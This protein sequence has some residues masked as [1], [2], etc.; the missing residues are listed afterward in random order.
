M[1]I[2]LTR[3]ISF[4]LLAVAALAS[5]SCMV[6]PKYQRPPAPVPQAFKESPPEGWKEA[7]P[8]DG[9]LRGFRRSRWARRLPVQ[10]CPARWRQAATS[11]RLRSIRLLFR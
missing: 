2:R 10:R 6:G 11:L 1:E 9:A 8:N 7:Q 5:T 4:V 3:H